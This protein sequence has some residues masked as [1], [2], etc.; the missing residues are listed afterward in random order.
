MR[1]ARKMSNTCWYD[2]KQ[3]DCTDKST[4]VVVQ[5]R[6]GQYNRRVYNRELASKINSLNLTD[7]PHFPHC[8]QLCCSVMLGIEFIVFQ[9]TVPHGGSRWPRGSKKRPMETILSQKVIWNHMTWG[10]CSTN[11]HSNNM[12][13]SSWP[14]IRSLCST[15]GWSRLATASVVVTL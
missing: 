12:W 6:T 7:C 10:Q 5:Q 2:I 8:S 1:A 11:E 3:L 13:L 4:T 14:Y 9:S 15:S